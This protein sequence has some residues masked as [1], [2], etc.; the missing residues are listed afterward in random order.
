MN[1]A[2]ILQYIKNP[3]GLNKASAQDLLAML[4]EFPYSGS[5]HALYL[6][7]LKNE[8][9]YLYTKQLKRTAIAVPDRKV[10]YH[11][12]EKSIE[13][14]I[15]TTVEPTKPRIDFKATPILEK[16][17]AV[18]QEITASTPEPKLNLTPEVPVALPIQVP[19]EAPRIAPKPVKE[20]D[21]DLL[22][23]PA[24]VRETVLKARRIREMYGQKRE[25]EK[26]EQAT[27]ESPISAPATQPIVAKIIRVESVAEIAELPVPV[28][29]E[30]PTPPA[31][32]ATKLPEPIQ[33]EDATVEQH[34]SII[35]EEPIKEPLTT[36]PDFVLSAPSE[37]LR[38]EKTEAT[39]APN[40]KHS[41][42]DWLKTGVGKP[43]STD[44]LDD[45]FE[46]NIDE[47]EEDIAE[48]VADVEIILP[49]EEPKKELSSTAM[50]EK[51][52]ESFIQKKN[53]K[54]P[55]PTQRFEAGGLN[56]GEQ[57]SY[58]TETLAQ[59]YVGQKLYDRAI[60]AYEILR[61][62]YPEKSSFFAA[63]ISEIKELIN[64]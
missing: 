35:I 25:E 54:K 51:L 16:P 15:E 47:T 12:V 53:L 39:V 57:A 62:K 26:T 2:Q 11:W 1:S 37:P 19:V 40:E 27:S 52:A 42:L 23:L 38:E 63:R 14:P 3:A 4:D 46:P 44:D 59:I 33:D 10:L 48:S 20:E 22:H 58:I 61:L 56:T 45:L 55:E 28:M 13:L 32:E 6:K 64:T 5:L 24:S 43:I 29:E 30:I 18:V 50:A 36:Q 60:N 41:F 9:N 31:Y 21:L 7:A 8:N 17:A 34:A 49:K